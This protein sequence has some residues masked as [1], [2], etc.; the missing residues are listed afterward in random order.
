M[1]SFFEKRSKQITEVVASTI[2]MLLRIMLRDLP[3]L[4][5][6][7]VS[8]MRLTRMSTAVSRTVTSDIK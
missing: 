4:E 7:I 2:I 3:C 6:A 1:T 8:K 5:Q